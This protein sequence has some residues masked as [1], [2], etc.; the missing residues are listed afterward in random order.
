MS[1]TSLYALIPN[2]NTR[3]RCGSFADIRTAE[4]TSSV[5]LCK[6]AVSPI[7]WCHAAAPDKNV[8]P[9]LSYKP[10]KSAIKIDSKSSHHYNTIIRRLEN[11]PLGENA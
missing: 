6:S 4:S 7:R 10:L 2:S 11:I 1:D 8:K 3:I 9:Y 5:S